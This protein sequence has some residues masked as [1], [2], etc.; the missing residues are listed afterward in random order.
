MYFI[1]ENYFFFCENFKLQHM[2]KKS[3]PVSENV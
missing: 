1:F 2:I 3:I